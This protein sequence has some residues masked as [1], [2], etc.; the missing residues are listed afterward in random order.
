[1]YIVLLGSCLHVQFP[2][3]GFRTST[4]HRTVPLGDL[5][6]QRRGTHRVDYLTVDH[7]AGLDLRDEFILTFGGSA[8]NSTYKLYPVTAS[9]SMRPPVPPPAVSGSVLSRDF[10]VLPAVQFERPFDYSSSTWGRPAASTS[11][12]AGAKA[13]SASS[14]DGAAAASWCGAG[15]NASKIYSLFDA[16][17][18]GD[19]MNTAAMT[20]ELKVNAIVSPNLIDGSFHYFIQSVDNPPHFR[21]TVPGDK[22]YIGYCRRFTMDKKFNYLSSFNPLI[23]LNFYCGEILSIADMHCS[24]LFFFSSP[25]RRILFE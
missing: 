21:F 8:S 13:S 16:Y 9:S 19:V 10:R 3:A 12:S 23:Y 2:P 14:P 22:Q 4:V 1:M 11:S 7:D 25:S 18:T 17:A 15:R 6:H 5:A 20:R 24:P